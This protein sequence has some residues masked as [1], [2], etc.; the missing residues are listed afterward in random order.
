MQYALLPAPA[1]S[2][3]Q[4]HT[5]QAAGESSTGAHRTTSIGNLAAKAARALF[6]TASSRVTVPRQSFS[7]FC[8]VRHAQTTDRVW[9]YVAVCGPR[10]GGGTGPRLA[11]QKPG[12]DTNH[13]NQVASSD[14]RAKQVQHPQVSKRKGRE[15][16][17][18]VQGTS[19]QL[20]KPTAK[21]VPS[22]KHHQTCDGLGRT[23]TTNASVVSQKFRTKSHG[24]AH[25]PWCSQRSP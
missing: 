19:Q 22:T 13:V 23:P 11:K 18:R 1:T 24:H 7:A 14:A 9:A 20:A 2:A 5:H 17:S 15:R 16:H 4:R 8:C 21:V 25:L 10:E 3:A 12:E 6:I